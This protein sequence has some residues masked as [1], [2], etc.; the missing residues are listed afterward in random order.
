MPGFLFMRYLAAQMPVQSPVDHLVVPGA[1]SLDRPLKISM[2]A[3]ILSNANGP[4]ACLCHPQSAHGGQRDTG[5]P[6]FVPK[7]LLPGNNRTSWYRNRARLKGRTI[8]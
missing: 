2:S 5:W 7:A 8:P 6:L 3:R 1:R 4:A